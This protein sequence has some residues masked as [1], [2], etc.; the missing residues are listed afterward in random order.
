MKK[1]MLLLTAI[2]SLT[3]LTLAQ[4]KNDE[5][6][7]NTAN[8]F[9]SDLK[10]RIQIDETGAG[11]LAWITGAKIVEILASTTP[12]IIKVKVF[13]QDYKIEVSTTTNVIRQDWGQTTIGLS[14]FSIGDIINV[15]GK[16]DTTDFFLIHAKNLRNISIQKLHAAVEG[17]VSSISSS[18]NSFDMSVKKKGTSTVTINT[19]ANTKIYAGKSLKAFSDIQVGMKVVVRGIWDRAMSKIQALIIKTNSS[20]KNTEDDD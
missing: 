5:I 12:S 6:K 16:L 1:I 3:T 7:P 10:Q 2:A 14:E 11:N 9:K 13:G 18:T 8:V 4:A 20:D 19:D 17:R 15:Y